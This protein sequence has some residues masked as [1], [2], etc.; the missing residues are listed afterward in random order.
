MNR[1]AEH[2]GYLLTVHDCVTVPGLG[3]FVVQYESAFFSEDMRRC[4]SPVKTI[5][6]N[7]ALS[8]NDGLLPQSYMKAC[9]VSYEQ[10]CAMVE[11]DVSLLKTE[12]EKKGN[13]CLQGVGVFSRNEEG[14]VLFVPEEQSAVLGDMFGLQ[15]LTLKKLSDIPVLQSPEKQENIATGEGRQAD[16]VYIPVNRRFVRYATAIA[17]MFILL[18]MISTP[19]DTF[20]T[21]ADYASLLAAELSG[22]R[23]DVNSAI[24]ELPDTDAELPAVFSGDKHEA[25]ENIS[26]TA[27]SEKNK[28]SYYIVIASLVNR[29]AAELQLENFR[30]MGVTDDIHIYEG[31]GKVRLYLADFS[32][33]DEASRYLSRLLKS[34][35][36]FS[37]AWIF[38]SK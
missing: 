4:M 15:P 28:S 27:V 5:C 20:D 36:R 14:A 11:E 23:E 22:D 30:R 18:L 1:I 38:S 37:D 35:S 7:T 19:V 26:V 16:V 13:C 29:Q 12:L 25:E 34:G 31:K 10:A 9:A 24:A 21:K 33:F 6:F 2:I 8:H 32:N 17:A 3:G